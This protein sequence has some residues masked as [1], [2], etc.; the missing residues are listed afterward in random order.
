MSRW[1][2]KGGALLALGLVNASLAGPAWLYRSHAS[3]SCQ[4]GPVGIA[5]RHSGDF[6]LRRTLHGP[7]DIRRT[8][9]PRGRVVCAQE[10]KKDRAASHGTSSL[11]SPTEP[12]DGPSPSETSIFTMVRFAA[13]A[14]GIYL[15]DPIMTCIDNGFVG[16]FSGTRSLAALGPGNNL[17]G[18][19]LFIVATVLNTAVTGLLSRTLGQENGSQAARLELGQLLS[20]VLLIGPALM[21]LLLVYGGPA[22]LGIGNP[23]D[24]VELALPYVQIRALAAT[25]VLMQGICLSA[26]LAARDPVTPLKVILATAVFNI[27]GDAAV[28]C[29]PF[30]FGVVGAAAAT[31]VSQVLGCFLMLGALRRK[32]IL[33]QPRRISKRVAGV[34]MEYAGPGLVNTGSRVMGYVVMGTV[35]TTIGTVPA[36]AYQVAIGIFTVFAFVSAPLSQIA[37]TMLPAVLDDPDKAEMCRTAGR[38]LL[39]FTLWVG[40]IAAFLCGCMLTFGST[41]LTRDPAVLAEIATMTAGISLS[42][43][44]ICLHGA[45]DGALVAAKDF[46]FIMPSQASVCALQVVFLLICWKRKLSLATIVASFP[47][48]MVCFLAVAGLRIGLGYGPLGRALRRT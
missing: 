42:V 44:L 39:K 25:A 6:P 48:R 17:I 47:L 36:A 19:V 28:C 40:A 32:R 45:V 38:N 8:R 27:I 1:R 35:A 24:L 30:Q 11:T 18:N 14:L 3:R 7:G 29:W 41:L 43:F 20:I 4:P 46:R 10:L 22:M 13:P 33:P 23:Q 9:G 5:T 37:Q 12:S 15:A 21:M 2:S 31:T 16:R 34:V 26:L